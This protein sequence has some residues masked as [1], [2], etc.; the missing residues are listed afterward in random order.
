MDTHTDKIA[1]SILGAT[2]YTGKKLISFCQSHPHIGKLSLYGSKS[3]GLSLW[4]VLPEFAHT[5]ENT[6]ILSFEDGASNDDVF[7]IALPHGESMR[8]APELIENGSAVIDLGGDFRLKNFEDYRKWYRQ[9]HAAAK[10]LAE[11]LYGLADFGSSDY[12][13]THLIA[14]PGCYAT[15]VLLSLLPLVASHSEIIL[16]VSAIGYSGTSGAG[17]TAQSDLMMSEM[18]GNVRAY[19]VHAHRHEAEIIQALDGYGFQAP[20]NFAVHLLPIATGMYTTCAIHL[21]SDVEPDMIHQ[22]YSEAYS[23][24]AFVRLRSQPPHLNWVVGTNFCDIFVSVR[25]RSIIVTAAID[26]LIK[27]AAGQ[28]VQNLNKKFGWN[29]STGILE[30]KHVPIY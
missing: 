22:A 26:N 7:F 16:S 18:D 2:G 13:G 6:P 30:K 25:D 5:A 12:D 9:D 24:K 23:K 27:G 11:S 1:V 14:N 20:F 4:D 17:K 28:A 19:S 8:I 10:L 15:A 21:K 3:S 29:E